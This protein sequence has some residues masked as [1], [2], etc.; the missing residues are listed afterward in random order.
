LIGLDQGKSL[1]SLGV[2]VLPTISEHVDKA[3]ASGALAAVKSLIEENPHYLVPGVAITISSAKYPRMV[4]LSVPAVR[5]IIRHLDSDST[6]ELGFPAVAEEIECPHHSMFATFR[7]GDD[8]VVNCHINDPNESSLQTF[9]SVVSTFQTDALAQVKAHEEHSLEV[10]TQPKF[11]QEC[12]PSIGKPTGWCQTWSAFQAECEVL[13]SPLH[14]T[15]LR[16]ASNSTFVWTGPEKKYVVYM[17][18]DEEG[19]K[20]ARLFADHPER[21]NTAEEIIDGEKKTLVEWGCALDRMVRCLAVRYFKF[22]LNTT[23]LKDEAKLLA[24]HLKLPFDELAAPAA[25]LA[26]GAGFRDTC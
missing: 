26:V 15:L 13:E 21:L 3:I 9:E 20:L 25:G 1:E 17:T 6:A 8:G 14:A 16:I 18:W 24:D 2:K 22:M 4:A 23:S 7:F 12:D 19:K 5:D 11:L 10:P